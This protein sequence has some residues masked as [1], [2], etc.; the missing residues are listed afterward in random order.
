M[1]RL[2]F[3]VAD[4]IRNCLLSMNG[5]VEGYVDGVSLKLLIIVRP[6]FPFGMLLEGCSVQKYITLQA[7]STITKVPTSE[8]RM[9]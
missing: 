6:Y 7:E 9:A 3:G 2:A 5:S 4:G 8:A 1:N